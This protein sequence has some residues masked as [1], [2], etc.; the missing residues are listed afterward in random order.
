MNEAQ[1]LHTDP[2]PE[3]QARLKELA[4]DEDYWDYLDQLET[5]CAGCREWDNS[6]GG[7]AR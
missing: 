6:C 4:S 1:E 2:D 5:Y 7:G 3:A